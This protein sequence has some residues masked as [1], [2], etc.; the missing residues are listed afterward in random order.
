MLVTSESTR[1]LRR[2]DDAGLGPGRSHQLP[3]F[4]PLALEW[5]MQLREKSHR[6]HAS[7]PLVWLP[8]TCLDISHRRAPSGGCVLL[9]SGLDTHK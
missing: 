9:L 6:P 1:R 4:V 5:H 8:D 3:L 7:A 2:R